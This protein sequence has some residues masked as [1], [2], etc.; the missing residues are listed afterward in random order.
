MAE[1]IK[2]INIKLSLDGQDLD[3]ELKSINK[4]LREQQ[5]DL[6][7]IN[8][9]LRYDSSNLDL[10]KKKQNQLNEVIDQ[11]KKRLETQ[12]KQLEHARLG[13]KLG[14]TSEA[15][16]RKLQR[17]VT[18][19]E[20]DLKR[21]NNELEKTKDKVKDLGNLKFDNLAKVGSTLTK[22]LTA[23]ILGAVAALTAFA[24]KGVDTADSI[25]NTAKRLR[26]SAESL[27]EWNHVARMSGVETASLEKAFEKVNNI[28][29]DI[30][31]GNVKGFA[32]VFHALG[33]SMDEIDG[34]DTSEA[35]EVIR[36]ALEKVED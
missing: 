24:S 6:R 30:A 10:W 12:Q 17:N 1:T 21:L 27:Q 36:N 2:G 3:N 20:A 13:L 34:K 25:G 28:V 7:A 11:T 19:N 22:S 4:E 29:A 9:N 26:M 14:T 31:L 5:R 23:P 16:F 18:Y 15:E 35:F 32:G 33:I 8:T